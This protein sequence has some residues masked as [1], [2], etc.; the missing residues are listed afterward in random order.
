MIFVSII[1][2]N[3]NHAP[4]LKERIDSVL[5]QTF[6]NFEIIILDDCSK[7]NSREIIETFRTDFRVKH[8]IYSESNSGS[9]FK[10]WAKGIEIAQGEY[11]WIAESDDWCEP[12]LLSTLIDALQ[13]N[14]EVVLGYVQ[15]YYMVGDNKI[16]WISKQDDLEKII[17][18]KDFILGNMIEGN[19]IFNASMAVFKRSVYY[20]ISTS[21][22]QY[23]FCGDWFFWAAIAKNG[24]VFISGK[25]LNY[26]RNHNADVSGTAYSNGLN[27]IE[28]LQ[29]L[30]SFL[31][32]E[33]ITEA[34]FL[35]AI[36]AKHIR[37][38]Q[39]KNNFSE[40]MNIKIEALFYNDLRTKHLKSKIT[41]S[42]RTFV[43]KQRVRKCLE[44]IGL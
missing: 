20:Q 1:I 40:P 34:I 42:Y 30:F 11:I 12:S 10:Q 5:Q 15:S 6:Q 7:D 26:F 29:V 31:D 41:N 21:Y 44:K 38:R 36:D 27:F 14:P 43:L 24:N 17:A 18:G 4:F 25:V 23:K 22:T 19:S 33:L 35:K 37:Y 39:L 2:P 3:Y 8:I 28:E 13:K 9:P 16:K 32:D